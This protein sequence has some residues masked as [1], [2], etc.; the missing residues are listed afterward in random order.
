VATALEDASTFA[1][2]PLLVGPITAAVV[3]QGL[4]VMAEDPAVAGHAQRASLAMQ[5]LAVPSDFNKRF[6]WAVSNDGVLVAAWVSGN[7]TT[8]LNSLKAA[9]ASVWNA[10][11]GITQY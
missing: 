4:V 6:S 11:A 8:A 3:S 5:V 1:Q 9:V 2:D 7:K 10:V